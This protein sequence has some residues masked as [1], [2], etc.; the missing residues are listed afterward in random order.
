MGLFSLFNVVNTNDTEQPSYDTF[1]KYVDDLTRERL[2]SIDMALGVQRNKLLEQGYMLSELEC[3]SNNVVLKRNQNGF[4]VVEENALNSKNE[5]QAYLEGLEFL[6][7]N[8][9]T[10][11]LIHT[12]LL[13]KEI[14]MEGSYKAIKCDPIK[15]DK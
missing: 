15:L 14:I 7:K 11:K 4:Y 6:K 9:D 2:K 10:F 12:Y 8:K 5:Y 3:V 13:E 1:L